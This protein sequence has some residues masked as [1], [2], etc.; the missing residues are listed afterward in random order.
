MIGL[1]DIKHKIED[2]YLIHNKW[3]YIIDM[4]GYA[5]RLYLKSASRVIY[6]SE[7]S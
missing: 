1:S 4:E 3:A 2:C 7:A 6:A 5:Y